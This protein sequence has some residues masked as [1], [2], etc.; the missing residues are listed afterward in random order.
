MATAAILNRRQKTGG[1]HD[2]SAVD[3]RGSIDG[4]RPERAG[5][6]VANETSKLQARRRGLLDTIGVRIRQQH[7]ARAL[8][9]WVSPC[10]AA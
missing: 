6:V 3:I 8:Q 9:V 2:E 7:Q 1:R 5:H 4:R 10:V